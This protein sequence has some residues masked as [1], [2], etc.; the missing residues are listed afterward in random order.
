MTVERTET[1][2][3]GHAK[4]LQTFSC[5]LDLLSDDRAVPTEVNDLTEGLQGDSPEIISVLVNHGLEVFEEGG[6]SGTKLGAA[7]SEEDGE[8]FPDLDDKSLILASLD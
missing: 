7:V 6:E 5:N 1:L 4:A 3:V 2:H 8:K